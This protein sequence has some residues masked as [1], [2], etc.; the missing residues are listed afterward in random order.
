M[1]P[2]VDDYIAAAMSAFKAKRGEKTISAGG[3]T[4]RTHTPGERI[5]HLPNGQHVKV[6][7][8]DSGVATQVEDDEALHAIVRPQPIRYRLTVRSN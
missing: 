6:S 8:D 7:V 2:S 1:T 4:I 5:L 3:R